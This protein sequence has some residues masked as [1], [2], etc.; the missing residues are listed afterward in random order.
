MHKIDIDKP[1]ELLSLVNA[2]IFG[3]LGVKDYNVSEVLFN[4]QDVCVVRVEDDSKNPYAIIDLSTCQCEYKGGKFAVC[5]REVH[6]SEP[7]TLSER[8]KEYAS[9]A[10]RLINQLYDGKPYMFHVNMTAEVAHRFKHLIPEEDWEFVLAGVY[11][12]DAPEDA[13]HVTYNDVKSTFGERVAD[14]AHAL[15]NEKGKTRDERAN[16]KYYREMHEVPYA[17]FGKLCD[18][19]ANIQHG[20]NTGGSMLKRYRKEHEKFVART[21]DER[22]REMFDHLEQLVR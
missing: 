7:Q 13:H 4:N 15:Q 1:M 17:V 11:L 20:I 22:Y 16:D 10:H 5:N 18:R 3:G 12:H 19:I 8:A 14:F 6:D 2:E 9:K 21:F